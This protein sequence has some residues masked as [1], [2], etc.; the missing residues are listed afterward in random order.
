MAGD[1]QPPIHR[2]PSAVAQ[3]A[4]QPPARAIP[5][6]RPPSRRGPPGAPEPPRAPG[7]ATRGRPGPTPPAPTPPAWAAPLPPS[8][9]PRPAIRAAEPARSTGGATA[10]A[11]PPSPL[12]QRWPCTHRRHPHPG[13]G[14]TVGS[15]PA[16]PRHT[17]W[18]AYRCSLP[19]LA[20]F[21]SPRCAG[22][23][24][25]RPVSGADPDRERLGW[26]FDPAVADCGYRAP[27]PPRLARPNPHIAAR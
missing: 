19:G 17:R 10:V 26:E 12:P 4:A 18:L 25:Q 7:T 9:V 1:P 6:R 16:A 22:P 3:P 24:P 14:R 2:S 8:Y 21:T 27:L 23:G 15:G 20:G 5:R 11:D 13:A